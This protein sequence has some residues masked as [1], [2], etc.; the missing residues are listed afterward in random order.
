MLL[1]GIPTPDFCFD[2]GSNC[3]EWNE[4]LF[5]ALSVVMTFALL[6]IGSYLLLS[7]LDQEQRRG[8]LNF[9]RHSPRS[10]TNILGGKLIG[11]PILVYLA[12]ALAIPFQI[13]TALGAGLGIP[14]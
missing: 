13:K 10:A 14:E 2:S 7:D 12:I 11:V 4:V 3:Q 9:I 1:N 5:I 8:T 6:V